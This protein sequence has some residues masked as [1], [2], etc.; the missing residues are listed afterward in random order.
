M[1]RQ[2][3]WQAHKLRLMPRNQRRILSGCNF[4][5][6]EARLSNSA[7][8]VGA[9]HPRPHDHGPSRY[10]FFST[11]Y[12]MQADHAI[13][14][15]QTMPWAA[16]SY[17]SQ[18]KRAASL[19]KSSKSFMS[20]Q[21]TVA[22]LAASLL[23]T[24]LWWRSQA[25]RRWKGLK[26][27]QAKRAAVLRSPDLGRVALVGGAGN[28]GSFLTLHL[29][30]AYSTKAFDSRPRIKDFEATELHS[31]ALE[32]Q[33]LQEFGTV[34]FLG[35]CSGRSSCASFTA[36]ERTQAM[37]DDVVDLLSKMSPEQHLIVASSGSISEGRR[38]AKESDDVYASLL[39]DYSMAM[40]S[41]EEALSTVA[42]LWGDTCPW[43]SMLRFGAVL[44]VSPGQRTDLLV[45]SLFTGAYTRGV[46]RVTGWDAM[47]SWLALTDLSRAVETLIGLRR[48][49]SARFKIWNL[50]S[51]DAKI[52]KVATT[53]ASITGAKLDIRTPMT[54]VQLANKTFTGFSLDTTSFT[55]TY[56][57]SFKE[58]LEQTLV[59][60]DS[61]VP[62]SVT[63]KGPH[64]ADSIVD[65][66]PCPV[67]G[68]RDLQLVVDLGDQPYANDFSANVTQALHSPR[69]PLKLVRC[70]VC[71]HYHLSHVASRSNLFE[72]YLYRSGTSVTLKQHFDWLA[73]KVQ[74]ES[75]Q[76]VGSILELACN[77]GTQLDSFK[78]LG[79]KTYG[80]DPAKNIAA[81]AAA[82]KH[83]I[84]V[85]FW[86]LSFPE[87]PTGDALTAIT[88]QNVFAHVPHPVEFLKACAAVMGRKSKL[89]IQTSQCNMQQLGQF[90]TMYHEHIS[91]FTGH[92]FYKAAALAGL[93]IERFETVPIH[94]ESCLVTM[95]LPDG[96]S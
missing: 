21:G 55:K 43:I 61:K 57:F 6:L 69:F 95:Q 44:G 35:G 64:A 83:T 51:F 14:R 65:S 91:F 49:V 40:L 80:V 5:Y 45:P 79:W 22:V 16:R 34:I 92:S 19:M 76:K 39:D 47:R 10:V 53:V 4:E 29:R 13:A 60:F 89:Y 42:E 59:M 52:L 3:G 66:I 37:V 68:S 1:H 9:A 67:C 18:L 71:N 81:L 93:H 88:A 54:G 20:T 8:L 70:R 48:S 75:G 62:D 24:P 23:A 77:D 72:H 28:I 38:Y 96:H 11:H 17:A 12:I 63:P 41:R 25:S 56:N 15:P 82:K 58:D 32:A 33:E 94:G 2:N 73:H 86:P 87:L 30:P 85:G 46:L 50:A 36:T 31:S 7:V 78:A 26:P 84:R 74:Q 90:D 27:L